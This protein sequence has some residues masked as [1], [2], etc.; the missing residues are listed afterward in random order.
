MDIEEDF[1][2]QE[3]VELLKDR[4]DGV[5]GGFGDDASSRGLDQLEFIEGFWWESEKESC[6]TL[7]RR[8]S[9]MEAA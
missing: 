4:G 2:D 3:S 1:V 7:N 5:G 9:R 6:N 8:W